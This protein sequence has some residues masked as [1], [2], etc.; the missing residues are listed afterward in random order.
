VTLHRNYRSTPEI[1]GSAN[2]VMATADR[3]GP[4]RAPRSAAAVRLRATRESGATVTFRGCPDEI[5]EA[6]TVA[7]D[8]ATA[9]AG[10][11]NPRDIAIL[12]R[13]NA[14]SESFE[15]ALAERS[16][17]FVVRGSDRFFDRAEVRQAV[18]HW[19]STLGF[20][21]EEVEDFQT[22][23]TEAVTNAV[24]HGS[25]QGEADQFLV[26]AYRLIDVS[27]AVDVSDSGP[28]LRPH[29][30]MPAMPEPEATSGRGLPLMQELADAIQYLPSATG[31]RVRLIKKRSGGG[32]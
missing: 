14:Q 11:A 10:G 23:I 26:S 27:L 2:S 25:P 9:V 5:A 28:G 15:E 8:V 12:F 32:N 20:L 3:A 22:A 7:A 4:G 21:R 24:R 19:M 29:E 1:I 31:M 17:P 6:A 13:I 16:V 30:Q 18:A